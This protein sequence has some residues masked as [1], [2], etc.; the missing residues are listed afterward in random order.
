M[1]KI[2]QP[3]LVPSL[4]H[5]F[6]SS[7][8]YGSMLT[9]NGQADSLFV[10]ATDAYCFPIAQPSF[11]NP[12]VTRNGRNFTALGYDSN[13]YRLYVAD[14]KDFNQKGEAYVY[15]GQGTLLDSFMVGVI[16]GMFL[17]GE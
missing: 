4:V 2:T 16:P 17:F 13:S 8:A 14:G 1:Y 11:N 15:D 3:G 10:L 9:S 5:A 12:L 7:L 6:P